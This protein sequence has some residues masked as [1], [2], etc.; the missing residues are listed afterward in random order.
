MSWFNPATLKGVGSLLGGI[1]SIAGGFGLGG[2]GGL[3]G[4]DMRKQIRHQNA[5]EIL[6][7]RGLKKEGIHPLFA[8]GSSYNFSPAVMAGGK[9]DLGAIGAGAAQLAQG[10]GTIK[11]KEYNETMQ[12]L[13]LRQAEAEVRQSEA[14]AQLLE[15]ELARATQGRNVTQD[16]EAFA[17]GSKPAEALKGEV[18]ITG[19]DGVRRKVTIPNLAEAGEPHYGEGMDIEAGIQWLR[20][21]GY[22]MGRDS[23]YSLLDEF[24]RGG[25]DMGRA[26]HG[27]LR[28]QARAR[29]Q[30]IEN[31]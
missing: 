8:L 10:I 28:S 11:N 2:G 7:L 9:T 22:P 5:G 19:A 31:R 12:G 23:I 17:Y 24:R 13:G 25:A 14:Q 30:Y 18:F 16:A 26:I 27:F 29:R 6:R 4:S 15:S 20:D 21:R 1:G 3:S